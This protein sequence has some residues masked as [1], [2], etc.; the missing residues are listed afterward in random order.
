M[1]RDRGKAAGGGCFS[2]H[3]FSFPLT[4][5]GSFK[6]SQADSFSGRYPVPGVFWRTPLS[7]SDVSLWA[8]NYR[9]HILLAGDCPPREAGDMRLMG[10]YVVE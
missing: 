8:R 6:K 1:E 2:G 9:Q 4:F 7:G 5:P 3:S 10:K